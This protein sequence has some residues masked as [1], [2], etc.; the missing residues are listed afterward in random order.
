[1]EL[2][3]KDLRIALA[4][5][6][7]LGLP[8]E[9]TR[10]G[11]RA[12][13][14]ARGRRL[15][16]RGL[17]VARARGARR[18]PLVIER[19]L[20]IRAA[21]R[22]R[23][24]ALRRAR[25]PGR[26]H[27]LAPALARRTRRP[28]RAGHVRERARDGGA[29]LADRGALGDRPRRR[30]QRAPRAVRGRPPAGPS[31]ALTDDPDAIHVAGRVLARRPRFAFTHTV[32]TASTSTSRSSR[33]AGRA[34]ASWRSRAAGR[35]RRLVGARHPRAARNTPFDHDLFLVDP[36]SGEA[37][38]A[39]ARTTARSHSTR[40]GCCPTAPCSALPTAE[41][42]RPAGRA[43][44]GAGRA[45]HARRRRR[46][47]RR[48]RRGARAP[49]LDGQPRRR[50]RSL[51]RRRAPRRAC[52]AAS[53]R[54]S[55]SR[56]TARS[57]VT[58]GPPDDS[59]DVWTAGARRAPAHALRRGRP[60]PLGVRAAGARARGE[61]RRPQHPVPAL[62]RG[63]APGAVL[64]AR[65][66][67]IPVPPADGAGHPG[68]CA[69]R[70]SPSR[71]PTCEARRAMAAPTTTSTTSSERLDSV[72]DLAALAARSAPVTARPSA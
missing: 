33:L 61:L 64:G 53:S 44:R 55:P 17:L 9:V 51:A 18:D 40:R 10:A 32:A 2:H 45:A 49:G 69:L 43:P 1:M 39:H 19:Y 62:R 4:E 16:R 58:A 27:G 7:R 65:R 66:A 22:C 6:D 24:P 20:Q 67:G 54:H 36:D 48:A 5:A 21:T 26:C 46:R 41:R 15:R 31:C 50:E 68:T 28:A 60:R 14:A 56:P 42:V 29:G 34:G 57:T 47:D 13:A 59:T 25:L 63:R 30:R 11:R 8:M 72:S 38:A 23:A 37:D 52:R 3:L 71:R 35:R 70:A 12:G